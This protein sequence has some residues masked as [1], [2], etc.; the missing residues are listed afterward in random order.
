MKREKRKIRANFARAGRAKME[1]KDKFSIEM[2]IETAL[3]FFPFIT[4]SN[5]HE[6]FKLTAKQVSDNLVTTSKNTIR[7]F[8]ILLH[9]CRHANSVRYLAVIFNLKKSRI[10]VILNEQL[11]FWSEKLADCINMKDCQILE[12][13]FLENCV[14]SVDGVEF[15]IN[16]WIG[17][18]Y[19]GKQGCVHEEMKFS[20]KNSSHSTA[21]LKFSGTTL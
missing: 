7:D 2:V 15:E 4:E 17:D 19:S 21:S 12:G 18:S 13:F 5:F 3:T 10:S 16:A 1:V 20:F 14:G 8:L 11:N 9:W 6:I